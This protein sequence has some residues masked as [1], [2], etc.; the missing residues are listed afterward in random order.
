[1]GAGVRTG[2]HNIIKES[3]AEQHHPYHHAIYRAIL[4]WWMA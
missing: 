3:A 2:H 1:M 4:K